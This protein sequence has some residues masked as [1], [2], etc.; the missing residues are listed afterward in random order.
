LVVSRQHGSPRYDRTCTSRCPR[1]KCFRFWQGSVHPPWSIN[2]LRR[3]LFRWSS[4]IL[5]DRM[6]QSENCI[7]TPPCAVLRFATG[8]NWEIFENRPS[9]AGSHCVFSFRVNYLIP[10]RNRR[11]QAPRP[12]TRTFVRRFSTPST[13]RVRSC[14]MSPFELSENVKTANTRGNKVMR[15][16]HTAKFMVQILAEVGDARCSANSCVRRWLKRP[17]GIYIFFGIFS[18]GSFPFA[19]KSKNVSRFR[20]ANWNVKEENRKCV[21]GIDI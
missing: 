4:K 3:Q 16:M 6:L 13:L 21:R 12:N 17:I 1:D 5:I 7:E 20:I 11:G 10:G 15:R 9:H 2:R 14:E 19:W 18:H 8:P